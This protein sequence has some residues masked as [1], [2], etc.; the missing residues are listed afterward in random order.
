M[1]RKEKAGS[2]ASS[3]LAARMVSEGSLTPWL[4]LVGMNLSKSRAQAA[5]REAP[6]MKAAIYSRYGEPEVLQVTDIDKP[7]PKD[8]EVLIRVHATTVCAGDVRLRRADPFFLRLFNGLFRPKRIKVPG[9]EFSGTIEQIGG[10]VADFAVGDRVF[11]SAGLKFGAYAEYLCVSPS[12][13]LAA[14]PDGVSLDEAAAIPFGG[15]SAL[16]F[17]RR[18]NIEP[19]R[20]VLI[21]GASGSVGTYA[22]QLARHLGARVTG[23]CS[24]ANLDLVRSLGAHRV[25]D[26]SKD[27]FSSDGCVYD[28]VFDT[29]G[30][31]GF[32]RSMRV[33][34][35]GGT[36]VQASSI[37]VGASLAAIISGILSPTLGGIWAATAGA[38]KVAGGNAR[39]QP[40]DLAL[41]AGL[42]G[43]GKLK[44]VID[45]RYPLSAIADAHR[46]VDTGR[47]RG[48]VVIEVG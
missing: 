35:R 26:Y 41:L 17:L 27:D 8:G 29:V 19:D 39:S 32:W 38:G 3:V 31:S 7:V 37:P 22:V 34:R 40:G 15:I 9:M 43:E 20:N 45:R 23:V 47:K 1:G 10:S 2:A 13:L 5:H 48:N 33:L 46:Y 11:G 18:A 36:F 14:I 12:Q 44:V 21:Y 42:V 24:A 30:K 4:A 16:F 25:I 28:V 6:N